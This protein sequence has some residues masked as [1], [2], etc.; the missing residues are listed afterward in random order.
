MLVLVYVFFADSEI[1][2]CMLIVVCISLRL[3]RHT[4]S[5]DK[6]LIDN[7]MWRSTVSIVFDHDRSD[8]PHSS[9]VIE[10]STK[11]ER[12]HDSRIRSKEGLERARAFNLSQAPIASADG[13][14]HVRT[15][16]F[17]RENR[18]N[19]IFFY[20]KGASTCLHTS[21]QVHFLAKKDTSRRHHRPEHLL[22]TYLYNVCI[23]QNKRRSCYSI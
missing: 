3:A 14:P 15:V 20:N 10:W 12:V 18:E 4:W 7:S 22:H 16:L 1:V 17:S 2:L 6:R 11:A 21:A 23:H 8:R 19:N 9:T 5:D 13:G